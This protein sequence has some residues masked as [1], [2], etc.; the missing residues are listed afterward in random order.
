ML[1]EQLIIKALALRNAADAFFEE[2]ERSKVKAE[3]PAPRKRQNLKAKR[4]EQIAY[5]YAVGK[6]K[7][8]EHLKK[9]KV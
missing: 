2:L 9:K 3:S 4:I 7:K 6:W 1:N 8:P 5:N